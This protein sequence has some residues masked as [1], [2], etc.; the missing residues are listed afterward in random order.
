MPATILQTVCAC[1]GSFGRRD[2]LSLKANKA[3][4]GSVSKRRLSM[5]AKFKPALLNSHVAS[6]AA[7]DGL[8]DLLRDATVAIA[9]QAAVGA[10]T[11][12]RLCLQAFRHER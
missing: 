6:A 3:H 5:S 10:K 8:K 9:E 2:A 7:T 1:D 12:C 11:T 4:A